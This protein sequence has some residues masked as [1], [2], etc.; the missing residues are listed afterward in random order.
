MSLAYP[1]LL[2]H[3]TQ[4]HQRTHRVAVTAVSQATTWRNWLIGAWIF[5]YEQAG[6]DRAAYGE[7]LL[8]RLAE[9]LGRGVLAHDRGADCAPGCTGTVT[10]VRTG[11]Q[12]LDIRD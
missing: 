9:D 6:S 1:A 11:H 5:E 12:R 10:S 8:E 3:L 7:R 4:V 2:E